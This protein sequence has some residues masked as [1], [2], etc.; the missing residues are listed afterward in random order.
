MGYYNP[1]VYY[2]PEAFGLELVGEISWHEPC[3]DFDLTA[4]WK[5]SRGEYYLASDSGC[6]CPSPFEDFTSVESLEGPMNKDSLK[7]RLDQLVKENANATY[8]YSEAELRKQSRAILN[9]LR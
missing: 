5:K 4:V 9:R 2:Q 1:D 7:S 8:G 3:Y 6:S